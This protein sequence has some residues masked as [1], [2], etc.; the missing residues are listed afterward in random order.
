MEL[1]NDKLRQII[2]NLDS[3]HTSEHSGDKNIFY[4]T[5]PFDAILEIKKYK[6][7]LIS[8]LKHSN[9]NVT[10]LSIGNVVQDFIKNNPRRNNWVDFSKVEYKIEMTDF[11]K[12]IGSAIIENKIIE[13]AILEKQNE[14]KGKSKPLLLLTDLEGIHPFTRFGP[15]EQNIYNSVEIPIVILYPGELSGSSLD[16]LGFYPPDGNYRSKHY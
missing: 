3:P 16:F 10:T 5:F 9:Y 1:L 8:L 6:E 15:V 12:G 2:K 7:T 4:L 11:F 13:N 14:I